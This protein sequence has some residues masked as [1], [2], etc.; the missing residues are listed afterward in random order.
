MNEPGVMHIISDLNIGGGQ[1]VV[2]TLVVELARQGVRA[3][4]CTFQDGPLRAE[5]EQAGIPVEI[6]PDRRADVLALPRFM[7]DMRRIL[8]QLSALIKRYDVQIAQTHLLGSLD[9]LVLMLRWTNPGVTVFW[10]FHSANFM[11]RQEHL[12]RHRWLLGPKRFLHRLLYRLAACW[13]G[14][15][16]AVS[17]QVGDALLQT[18]GPGIRSKIHVLPNGV[19]TERYGVTVDRVAVRRALGLP[20]DSRVLI[21]VGTLKPVKGHT[22]TLAA[23]AALAER[24]PDLHALFVGDGELRADLEAQAAVLGLTERVHFLGNRSDVPALLA[25][26]DL[27]VLPSLW[28]GLSMALLEAMAAGLPVVVSAVSGAVQVVIPNETGYLFPPGDVPAMVE[29]IEKVL[30][31]PAQSYVVGEAGRRHVLAH[32]SAQKQARDHIAL[33]ST[34]R[35]EA[36]AVNE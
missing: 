16:V 35:L 30:S 14:G 29:A 19:D 28:E 13:V 27:F 11:L 8:R 1:A 24:Y 18:F 9:F 26:S 3:V 25:A 21:Q 32:F 33:Y 7:A 31:D 36:H 4:V 22:Y 12:A 6:L 20:P 2:R 17:E 15:F 5:I 23:L 10:T 34:V